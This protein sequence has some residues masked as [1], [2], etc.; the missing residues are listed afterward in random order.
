MIILEKMRAN[1]VEVID[2]KERCGWTN[3]M[4]LATGTSTRHLRGMA[5]AIT[6]EVG[7]CGDGRRPF[8]Q[9]TT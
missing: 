9:F 2:V 4:V 3:W 7:A 5:E 8:R 6:F 1:N